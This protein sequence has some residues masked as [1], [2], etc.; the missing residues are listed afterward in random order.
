MTQGR[1]MPPILVAFVRGSLCLCIATLFSG[2]L[3][4]QEPSIEITQVPAYGSYE[5]LRGRVSNVTPSDYHVAAYNFLEGLGWY[6]KP[7]LD[8][9][10]TPIA[11]DDTF[12]VNVT[13]GGVDQLAHRY[14]VFLVPLATSCPTAFGSEYLP[15]ELDGRPSAFV[16]RTPFTLQFSGYTWVQR[17][18]PY[19]GGPASNCFAPDHA[20]VDDLGQLHLSLASVPS[21]PSLGLCGGEIWLARSLGY[22]RY[23]I[24]TVGRIDNLDPAAVLGMFTWAPDARPAHLEMDIELSRWCVPDDPDNAQYVVQPFNLPGHLVRFPI[25]LT[26]E[27]TELTF[28]MDWGPAAVTF[29]VYRGHHFGDPPS[30]DLIFQHVFTD[31]VPVPGQERFRFNLW[32]NC[33]LAQSQEVVVTHFSH[34]AFAQRRYRR[35][36][37][38]PVTSV[39]LGTERATGTNAQEEETV[40]SRRM[41]RAGGPSTPGTKYAS[42][43]EPSGSAGMARG[44]RVSTSKQS[45]APA[46]SANKAPDA[47]YF[48]VGSLATTRVGPAWSTVDSADTVYSLTNATRDPLIGIL[49]LLDAT[50][51][52]VST[53]ALSIAPGRTVRVDTASLGAPRG[54]TGTVK[55]IHDGPPGSIR[56]EAAMAAFDTRSPSRQP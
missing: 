16:E 56:V 28:L 26:D 45:L 7:T 54:R 32:R 1:T 6:I 8:A 36:P 49:T 43:A 10:C 17:N 34:T 51:V 3:E 14:A 52:A 27:S 31:G 39:A 30:V 35:L 18:S 29:S 2:M 20:T 44:S 33:P 4:A 9:P 50:G 24:H 11:A 53:L 15:D 12:E 19:Y 55:L 41:V 23:R 47:A 5:H 37:A 25:Q 13:T 22:G 21:I 38:E 40:S 48:A 42:T 46:R